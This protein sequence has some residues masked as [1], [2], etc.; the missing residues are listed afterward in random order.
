ME[1]LQFQSCPS[2]DGSK[3]VYFKT[4]L[5]RHIH[6]INTPQ[7]KKFV[8]RKVKKGEKNGIDI[9]PLVLQFIAMIGAVL[10][11][12]CDVHQCFDNKSIC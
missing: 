4:A 10:F 12:I 2:M 1:D 11:S 8:K 7:S 6:E 3:L 5:H 9:P